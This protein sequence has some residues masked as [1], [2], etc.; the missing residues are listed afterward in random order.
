MSEDK[1]SVI[2]FKNMISQLKKRVPL[3]SVILF[4]SQAR[5]E[6]LPE[7]DYDVVIIA[8]FEEKYLDRGE[9]V[10]QLAPDVATDIFCYTPDEFETLFA[11]YN[12]TALD[13]IAEGIVLY[14]KDF[15]NPYKQRYADFV[16]RGLKKEDCVLVLPV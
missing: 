16:R 3:K 6:A 9:W 5:G 10:V 7:S 8:E 2:I 14:G 11:Q 15:V 13:A 1:I 4:G 12:L